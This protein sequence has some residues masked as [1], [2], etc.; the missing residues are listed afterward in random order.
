MSLGNL[1]NSSKKLQLHLC[2]CLHTRVQWHVSIGNR[3]RVAKMVDQ[4]NGLNIY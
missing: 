4:A 2:V 1:Y 3:E